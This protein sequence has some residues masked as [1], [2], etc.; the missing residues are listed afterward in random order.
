MVKSPQAEIGKD[1]IAID[2]RGIFGFGKRNVIQAGPVLH[3]TRTEPKNQN[4]VDSAAELQAV[5]TPAVDAQL[6]QFSR[7]VVDD[8]AA[9]HD[10]VV[11]R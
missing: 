7:L 1:R 8:M 5:G 2:Q 6:A 3:Q 11:V 10:V 4:L 9:G